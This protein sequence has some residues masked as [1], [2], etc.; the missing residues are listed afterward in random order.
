MQSIPEVQLAKETPGLLS[1]WSTHHQNS[2]MAKQ[3]AK[4][5]QEPAQG[6]RKV[7]SKETRLGQRQDHFVYIKV[8]KTGSSTFSNIFSSYGYRH[9]LNMLMSTNTSKVSFSLL[10]SL[11]ALGSFFLAHENRIHNVA[12]CYI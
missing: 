6:V 10:Q 3:T 7:S 9:R 5:K 8:E 2:S 12:N 11:Y 1:N 4:P